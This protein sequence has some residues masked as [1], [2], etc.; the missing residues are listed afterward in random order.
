MSYL[1]GTSRSIDLIG[2]LARVEHGNCEVAGGMGRNSLLI[3]I[4]DGERF[5]MVKLGTVWWQ[6]TS[7]LERRSESAG[8]LALLMC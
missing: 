1:D 3:L 7:R 4:E 6:V 8:W 2:T 5:W